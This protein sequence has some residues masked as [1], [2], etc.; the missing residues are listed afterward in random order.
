M[1]GIGMPELIIILVIALLV[2]GASRLPEIG[3][4]IGK[5]IR[6]FKKTVKESPEIDV[7]PEEDKKK[8]ESEGK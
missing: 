1:F 7:T 8:I 5:A 4:G 6:N 3:S 2:F